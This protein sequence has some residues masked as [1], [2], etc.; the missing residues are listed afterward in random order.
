MEEGEEGGLSEASG[1]VS[2]AFEILVGMTGSQSEEAEK[3]T[4]SGNGHDF[5]CDTTTAK[6]RL[7]HHLLLPPNC[8][9]FVTAVYNPSAVRVK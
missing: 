6:A 9:Q 5:R 3:C 2:V 4:R 7:S 8:L 1:T